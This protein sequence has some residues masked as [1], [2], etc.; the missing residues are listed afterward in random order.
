MMTI[1]FAPEKPRGKKTKPSKKAP[2]RDA[3]PE[4]VPE[5]ARDAGGEAGEEAE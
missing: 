5:P 4:A 1:G 2:A 3:A